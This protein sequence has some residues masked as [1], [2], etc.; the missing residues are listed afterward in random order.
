M[1]YNTSKLPHHTLHV[2]ALYFI[3]D[4]ISLFTMGHSEDD[5]L[6]NT[7]MSYGTTKRGIVQ[8]EKWKALT[9][10]S[11]LLLTQYLTV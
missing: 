2:K 1:E 8:L 9:A 11:P 7:G 4:T 5:T 6:N 10:G 3:C